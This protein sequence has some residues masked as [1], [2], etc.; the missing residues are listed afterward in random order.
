MSHP[1]I[2]HNRWWVVVASALALI[3][4]QGAIN[5]F[6]AGVFLKP[7][8]QELGFGRGEISTAIALSNI[9]VAIATPFFGRLI[10]RKGVRAPL[11]ISIILFALATAAMSLLQ[12][13]TAILLLLYGVAGLASVGQNPTAYSKVVSSWFDRERGLALGLTLA[14]VGLGTALIPQLSNFLI[15]EFGW[16][17]GYIGLGVAIVV[18]AFIP[19][20]LFLREPSAGKA[21]DSALGGPL[22]G[23]DFAEAVRTWRYWAM[24]FAFFIIATT[25]NGSL[26]HIVPLLTDRGIPVSDA[27]SMISAAGLALIVGRV[28]AGYIIDRVFAPYVAV[29]FLLGPLT[30][31]A[32][33]GTGTEAVSPVIGTILLGLGIGAEIDLMSFIV[34]RYFGIRAFGTLHGLMFSLVVLGNAAGASAL[35]WSF[36]LLH[37]YGPAFAGFGVL[38][39]IACVLFCLLGP[40]RYPARGSHDAESVAIREASAA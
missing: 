21:E 37:S 33:L 31:L 1:N 32:I 23:M 7:V 6:A 8:A 36:Q 20:W 13:S 16:R 34:T 17:D 27:V 35:G 40:Y 19:T 24:A 10:D 30:G 39:V 12:A 28:I 18:L 5:V 2:L 15:R 14:G 3:V 4:G 9:M 29:F 25:V 22:P 11:L 38:L 26:V